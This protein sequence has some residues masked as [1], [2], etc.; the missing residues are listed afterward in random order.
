MLLSSKR[1]KSLKILSSVMCFAWL[2][3]FGPN[4]GGKEMRKTIET[5]RNENKQ[6]N[7][8]T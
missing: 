1:N 4:R 2:Q 3:G 7:K 8:Q 6:T 5:H